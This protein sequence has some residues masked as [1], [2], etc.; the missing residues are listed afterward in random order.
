MENIRVVITGNN[1]C[2]KELYNKALN[3]AEKYL[4]A[5]FKHETLT[6]IC[7][8][9]ANFDHL[10]IDLFLNAT[11][12]SN[13]KALDVYIP[14]EFDEKKFVNNNLFNNLHTNFS[15]VIGKNTF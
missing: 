7:G 5:R 3:I 8:G 9:G 10:A 4:S 14:S 1:I 15:E 6:L 2:T 13:I 12:K 11:D